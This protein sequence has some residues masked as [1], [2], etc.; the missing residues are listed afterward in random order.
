MVLISKRQINIFST[1]LYSFSNG[2]SVLLLIIISFE[3]GCKRIKKAK[4]WF[5]CIKIGGQWLEDDISNSSN[6]FKF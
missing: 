6:F 1:I 2:T 3:L 5:H 4:I